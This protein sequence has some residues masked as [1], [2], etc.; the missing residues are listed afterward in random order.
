M[1]PEQYFQACPDAR[2]VGLAHGRLSYREAGGGPALVFLHGMNG[3]ALSWGYQFAQFAGR[4]RVVAW[5]APGYGE[6]DPIPPSTQGYAETLLAFLAAIECRRAVVVGHSMG[7]MVAARA[8]A[9][10][11]ETIEKLVLS[12]TH[13]G[14]GDLEDAPMSR[15]Y[16]ARVAERAE[17]GAVEYGRLRATK[18]MAPTATPE[19]IE[20]AT[21]IAADADLARQR[22][23]YRMLQCTD[24]RAVLPTL[25]QPRLIIAGGRDPVVSNARREEFRALCPDARYAMIDASGHAPYIETPD[26]YNAL[27][28]EFAGP[29]SR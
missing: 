14:Q 25:R 23:A 13:A 12:C 28:E 4:C 3:G 2:T 17:L 22:N 7:G 24:N 16:D 8:A 11:G 20:I 19:A 21:R 18:M 29:E 15:R 26:R 27:I 9:V 6:S 5:D 1:T 10:P